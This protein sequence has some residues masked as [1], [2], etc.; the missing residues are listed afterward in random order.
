MLSI[1]VILQPEAKPEISITV[2]KIWI[3]NKSDSAASAANFLWG[4]LGSAGLLI[5]KPHHG[6][7]LIIRSKVEL[8]SFI[9]GMHNHGAV[10]GGMDPRF[11]PTMISSCS[12]FLKSIRRVMET[13]LVVSLLPVT[14]GIP[15]A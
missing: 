14:T 5:N 13:G 2:T 12:G 6:V 9:A 11:S 15:L 4:S 3:E 1:F 8:V 7:F 10:L